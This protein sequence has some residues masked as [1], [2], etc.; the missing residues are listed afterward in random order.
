MNY[1]YRME[2]YYDIY[3]KGKNIN[4][5]LTIRLYLEILKIR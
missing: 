3:R 2:E 5:L 4:I 1:I